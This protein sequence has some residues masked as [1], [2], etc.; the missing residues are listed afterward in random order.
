MGYSVCRVDHPIIDR[1]DL[2]DRPL[3]SY[4]FHGKEMEKEAFDLCL[5]DGVVSLGLS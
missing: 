5:F 3:F 2:Y 4:S 1:T